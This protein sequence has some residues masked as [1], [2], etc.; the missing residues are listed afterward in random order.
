[1]GRGLSKLLILLALVPVLGGALLAQ[2]KD[3]PDSGFGPVDTSAPAMPPDQIVKQFAAK[4]SEFR[5]AL[6][7][8]TYQRDVRIQTINDDGK[9]DAKRQQTE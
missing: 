5:H 7:N 8:Y 4:E 9:V 3:Q 2:S 6:D 1:M